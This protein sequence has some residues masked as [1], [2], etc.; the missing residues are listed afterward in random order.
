MITTINEFRKINESQ[1]FT[2]YSSEKKVTG[3]LTLDAGID[4]LNEPVLNINIMQGSS[5]GMKPNEVKEMIQYMQ[6]WL[7][8]NPTI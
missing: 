5:S 3:W 6:K 7:I 2:S 4:S 1:M 8:E